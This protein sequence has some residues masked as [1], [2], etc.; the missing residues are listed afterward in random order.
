MATLDMQYVTTQLMTI[1]DIETFV[2]QQQ[3]HGIKNQRRHLYACGILIV[4][5]VTMI[6]TGYSKLLFSDKHYV[7][8]SMGVILP[9][10]PKHIFHHWERMIVVGAGESRRDRIEQERAKITKRMDIQ[11]EITS[12]FLGEGFTKEVSG[13]RRHFYLDTHK[14]IARTE[15]AWLQIIGVLLLISGLF[16]LFV[17]RKLYRV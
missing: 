10:E 9:D 17:E 5:A 8:Q 16:G 6:F 14:Y 1:A 15:N 11:Y 4:L 3:A 13:G 7:Y 12:S 2:K